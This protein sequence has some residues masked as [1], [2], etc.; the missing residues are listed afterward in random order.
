MEK[1]SSTELYENYCRSAL[2]RL[3]KSVGLDVAYSR[4]KGNY[5][6]YQN[7]SGPVKILDLIGGYGA[8]LHGHNHPKLVEYFQTLLQDETPVL[9]QASI[10]SGAGQLAQKLNEIFGDHKVIFTNS[11]A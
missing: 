3:L 4:A 6:W 2:V 1:L 8:T 10:R 11:R 7:E 9:A 5:L